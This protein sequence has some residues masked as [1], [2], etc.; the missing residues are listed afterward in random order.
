MR[1]ALQTELEKCAIPTSVDAACMTSAPC[2]TIFSI[3]V[4][5]DL[6]DSCKNG[7]VK[8]LDTL[9]PDSL[10]LPYLLYPPYV[11]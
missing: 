3:P 10:N 7:T 5:A 8:L 2:P 6:Q 11:S 1:G 4:I 9:H